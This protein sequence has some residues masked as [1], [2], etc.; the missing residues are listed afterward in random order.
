MDMA[1]GLWELPQTELSSANLH[2]KSHLAQIHHISPSERRRLKRIEEKNADTIC[3]ACRER[4]HAAKDC[5]KN[6]NGGS[7]SS[8]QV[9]MCYRCGS[10]RHSLS[11]CKKPEDPSNP[12]PW[13]H[14][15]VCSNQGH[16]ASTCPQ[17]KSKGIYPNGG[18]CKLCG[19][20]T[21]L[22]KDCSIRKKDTGSLAAVLGLEE[23]H[24]GADEDDFH[25]LGRRKQELDRRDKHVEQVQRMKA[26]AS[27][28]TSSG[29][30]KKVVIF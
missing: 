25:T 22:A 27:R 18:S 24:V 26:D 10:T 7:S 21:H 13:A 2:R 16:L 5:P 28:V 23:K 17:N 30:A 6:E 9:G 3:Y 8:K 15:F 19:D 20:I 14:C 12:L 4:G 1:P 11:R 29:T